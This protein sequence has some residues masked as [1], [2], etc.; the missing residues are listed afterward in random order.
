MGNLDIFG[1]KPEPKPAA[2]VP[3]PNPPS[4][5]DTAVADP[6]PPVTPSV[7]KRPNAFKF[8][9]ILVAVIVVI[10]LLVPKVLGMISG[11]PDFPGPGSGSVRI[12]IQDG[13]TIARI[14][15][16]LKAAGVVKSVDAFISAADDN[17]DSGK[18]AAGLYDLKLEMSAKDAVTALLDPASKI[19]D[20]VVIPEGKRASWIYEEISK[21]TG[22]PVTDFEAAATKSDEIGLPSYANGNVEGFLFPATY[23][24]PPGASAIEILT[25]MVAKFNSEAKR[26]DLEN[27]A[28]Q[29]GRTP[30]EIVTVASLLQVEGHPRDFEKVATVVYNRLAAPMRLQFDSTVNYGLGKTDVILTTDLLNKDTP[31]NMYLHDGLPPTPIDNPGADALEAALNPAIGDWLY[32]ITTDLNTQETKFTKSYDEFLVFKDEFLAFCDANAGTCW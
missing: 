22:I 24:F 4:G 12:E 5:T 15:N 30:Y 17:P 2:S 25:T 21:V 7:S 13:D 16:T 27:R 18:I 31:Y 32:F 19:V 28:K 29:M 26:L 23:D 8:L 9:A 20:N 11:A 10:G 3:P 1:D 6:L 14:G